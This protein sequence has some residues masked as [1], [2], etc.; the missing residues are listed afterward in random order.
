[1][2]TLPRLL[3]AGLFGLAVLTPFLW[4]HLPPIH[5]DEFLPLLPVSWFH[6]PPAARG[7]AAAPYVRPI[8]GYQVPL[9]SYPY[10]GSFKGLVYAATHLPASVPVFRATNLLL[11]WLLLAAVLHLTYRV[12]SRSP[13][14]AAWCLLFLLT[15]VACVVLGIT[16][17][18][19]FVSLLLGICLLTL[20]FTTVERPA[21]WKPLPIA[22]VVFLGEWDRLN[23]VWFVLAGL[24]GIAAAS[25]AGPLRRAVYGTIL[26]VVGCAAGL[27]ALD[28][29]IPDYRRAMLAGAGKSWK[30][31]DLTQLRNHFDLLVVYLDPF[32]AYHRYVNV[33]I[34]PHP[35]L[36]TAYRWAFCLLYAGVTVALAVRG[37]TTIRRAPERA[38]GL[39][40]VSAVLVAM[41]L[42]ILGTG[43]A[44]AV[45]HV[46]PVKPLAWVGL[47][48]TL[49]HLRPRLAPALAGAGLAA[50]AMVVGVIGFRDLLAAPA[51]HGI[52]DVSRNADEAWQAAAR[53]PAA[54]IYAL[55]WG[56]FY[57]GVV[58]S[59]AN[60]RW[61]VRELADERALRSLDAA[62]RGQDFGLLFRTRGPH[63]WL[64]ESD[65]VRQRLTILDEQRFEQH[66]GEPWALLVVNTARWRERAQPPPP[67]SP[68][69]LFDN[70]GFEDG[71]TGWL[72]AKWEQEPGGAQVTVSPCESPGGR[73][74]VQLVHRVPGDSRLIQK[75]LLAPNVLYEVSGWARAEGVGQHA[76]G[77]HLCLYEPLVAESEELRGD[78]SWT[79]LRFYVVSL[80]RTPRPVNI[81]VRLGTFGSVNTGSGWFSG[82]TVRAASSSDPGVP[83]YELGG[84]S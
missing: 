57:P 43:D 58:N 53:A 27:A 9:R 3:L 84:E 18:G 31:L 68:D 29:L 5:Q 62:R 63:R 65:T 81:A 11:V 19:R 2:S 35:T 10:E 32:G 42:L 8:F 66:K 83:V 25:L 51:I 34:P 39:L 36:Y 70:A 79:Q 67:A 40:F 26:G 38:R 13:E 78:T 71:T 23:F 61:D 77:V 73:R 28:R 14:A 33:L 6:K 59:P 47:G 64:L 12:G 56:V 74:C 37:L 75:V 1:L 49:A 69:N 30:V 82:L 16:D 20:L 21:W 46:L 50:A 48:L 7:V 45:H 72:Y 44:W 76:K 54:T 80:D 60:Q 4:P 55:D 15:D 41:P 24:A 22:L 52:Y 17:L